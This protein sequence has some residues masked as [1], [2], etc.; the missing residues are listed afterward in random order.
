M[1]STGVI[2]PPVGL[3]LWRG[4]FRSENRDGIFDMYIPDRRPPIFGLR[5]HHAAL[6]QFFPHDDASPTLSWREARQ[7]GLCTSSR[8]F[9]FNAGLGGGPQ[10]F[11]LVHIQVR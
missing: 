7:R 10:F 3:F 4:L 6:Y 5:H 1:A 9:R 2:D 8:N 11:L